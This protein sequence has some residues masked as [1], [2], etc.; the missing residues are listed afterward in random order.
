MKPLTSEWIAK[1]KGDFNTASREMQVHID[2]NYDAI[3]FHA[4]QCVEKFLKARLVEAAIDFPRT[5]DLGVILNHLVDIEPEWENL[6]NELNS[7]AAQAVEVRYPG[8]SADA[9]DSAM[10]MEIAKKIK[11]LVTEAL[12]I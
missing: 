1:A 2:P 12:K 3:C 10:A 8:C 11:C 6:R 9:E 7:L 5:H 4:Q